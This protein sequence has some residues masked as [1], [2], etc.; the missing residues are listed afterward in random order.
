MHPALDSVLHAASLSFV[1]PPPLS[2][3]EYSARLSPPVTQLLCSSSQAP[4][5]QLV[6]SPYLLTPLPS[7]VMGQLPKAVAPLNLL[8]PS[9][10][11]QRCSG[12]ASAVT[13]HSVQVIL[14]QSVH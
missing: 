11:Q 4:P 9:S 7:E 12:P 3:S 13:S 1:P 8:V 10:H 5:N 6:E 14:S 2:H